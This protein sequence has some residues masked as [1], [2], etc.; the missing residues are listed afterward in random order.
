MQKGKCCDIIIMIHKIVMGGIKMIQQRSIGLAILFTILT[1]GIYGIY[2]FIVLTDE[3]NTLS[4][5]QG[6]SGGMAFLLGLVTCGIY[7]IYWNYKMGRTME[8]A[9][10]RAGVPATDNSILFLILAIFGF[11]IIS[12]CIIQS[13]INKLAA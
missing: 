9:Q 4:G 8:Q 1:C 2:W 6:T 13:D 3:A 11:Q 5:E 12:Y 10:R 7:T